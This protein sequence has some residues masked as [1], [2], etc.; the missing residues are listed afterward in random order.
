M[1]TTDTSNISPGMAAL[2][3]A[4]EMESSKSSN[5]DQHCQNASSEG[6]MSK[7]EA[8]D[9]PRPSNKAS[10]KKR[11]LEREDSNRSNMTEDTEVTDDACSTSRAN[12]SVVSSSAA[13]L[14]DSVI[15]DTC[16]SSRDL[17]VR[18]SVMDDG[19]S[20]EHECEDAK[21]SSYLSNRPI[22][23]RRHFLNNVSSSSSAPITSDDQNFVHDETGAISTSGQAANQAVGT[24]QE[25]QAQQAFLTEVRRQASSRIAASLQLGRALSLSSSS[26]SSSSDSPSPAPTAANNPSM[27]AS[28]GPSNRS[29][30]RHWAPSSAAARSRR[31]L[32]AHYAQDAA[33]LLAGVRNMH[34]SSGVAA[35]TASIA[36]PASASQLGELAVIASPSTS[37]MTD[38]TS[39]MT[40]SLATA[41]TTTLLTTAPIV[42]CLTSHYEL[43]RHTSNVVSSAIEALQKSQSIH[44]TAHPIAPMPQLDAMLRRRRMSLDAVSTTSRT[45]LAVEA[46]IV[47]GTNKGA[48]ATATARAMQQGNA[49][50]NVCMDRPATIA[51]IAIP[52][53]LQRV[54][55]GSVSFQM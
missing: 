22:K 6:N 25:M 45:R 28:A 1:T 30:R 49:A 16:I 32:R 46:G 10:L 3:S 8:N 43:N 54:T 13:T 35:D 36:E 11:W 23:K 53:Y 51:G 7:I 31:A 27:V 40:P 19:R 18:G 42:Q 15:C 4:V 55:A 14:S 20:Y 37:P 34:V 33:Q 38:P 52:Y 50:A 21:S 41:P 12:S 9:A 17:R 39:T 26:S 44:F 48:A 5:D 24:K 47:V 29:H 2:L